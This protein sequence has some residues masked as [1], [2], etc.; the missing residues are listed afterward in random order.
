LRRPDAK[1]KASSPEAQLSI[2]YLR[3]ALLGENKAV[4]MSH[5]HHIK[6]RAPVVAQCTSDQRSEIEPQEVQVVLRRES[7]SLKRHR[8]LQQTHPKGTLQFLSGS[9]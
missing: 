3:R 7:V 6:N 1:P 8:K 2:T 5:S 9:K 4:H